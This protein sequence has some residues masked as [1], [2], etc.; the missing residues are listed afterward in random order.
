MNKIRV[1][2]RTCICMHT[3]ASYHLEECCSLLI[4]SYLICFYGY[5]LHKKYSFFISNISAR[6]RE[7]YG[8]VSQVFH[9]LQL[10]CTSLEASE[11]MVKYEQRGKYMPILHEV[12]C[13]NYFIYLNACR[14]LIRHGFPC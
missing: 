11:I 4:I 2:L 1:Q 14:N 9:I 6:C 8:N 12:T 3:S 13:N 5:V 7:Q 10:H